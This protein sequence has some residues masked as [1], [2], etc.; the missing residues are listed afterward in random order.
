MCVSVGQWCEGV[1]EMGNRGAF[2][3]MPSVF[4]L[5]WEAKSPAQCDVRG[6]KAWQFAIVSMENRKEI[7]HLL[8]KHLQ[9]DSKICS[10]QEFIL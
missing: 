2:H 3:L 5:K 9:T 1:K 6:G 10:G 4:S 8:K 7:G